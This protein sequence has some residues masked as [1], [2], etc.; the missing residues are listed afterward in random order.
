MKTQVAIITTVLVIGIGGFFFAYASN[1]APLTLEERVSALEARLQALES[2]L[3]SSTPDVGGAAA[4]QGG[5]APLEIQK[6]NTSL[7][8]AGSTVGWKDLGLWK[9]KLREGM[10][11]EEVVALFGKPD[12]V[13]SYGR[14]GERWWY[15][16]DSGGTIDFTVDGRVESWLEPHLR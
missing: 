16:S 5:A 11:Q 7:P 6:L 4:V 1:G 10:S 8:E 15:G 9:E 3:G 2:K 14:A 13:V 12:N